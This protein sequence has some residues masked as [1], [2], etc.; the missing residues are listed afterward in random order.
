MGRK[1]FKTLAK[2]L[3]EKYETDDPFKIA[4]HQKIQI[5]YMDFKAWL[6]LYAE[7]NG[8]K[9]IYINNNLSNI[10]QKI[11]CSHELG[12]GQQ[13]FK[14]AVFMKENYLFGTSKIENDANTFAATI[15][16]NKE[17][18]EDELSDYDIQILEE[19]KRYLR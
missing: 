17:I 4:R 18:N 1:C 16:F 6:G 11:V 15:I 14:E 3:I 10:L 19:L 2:G 12:H 7:I 9:T 8:V 13:N 5:I